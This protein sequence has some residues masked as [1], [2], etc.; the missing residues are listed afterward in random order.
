MMIGSLE[1]R[2]EYEIKYKSLDVK[3][4]YRNSI[5]CAHNGNI[6]HNMMRI[7]K[8]MEQNYPQLLQWF[9]EMNVLA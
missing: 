9:D 6:H 1:Q 7:R 5:K 3:T 2:I 4:A 8:H